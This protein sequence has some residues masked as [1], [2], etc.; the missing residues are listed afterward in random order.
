M[1]IPERIAVY[2]NSRSRRLS[3]WERITLAS[4]A[5]P[6]IPSKMPRLVTLSLDLKIEVM[7]QD[8]KKGRITKLSV[9]VIKT[10]SINPPVACQKTGSDGNYPGAYHCNDGHYQGVSNGP[11]CLPEDILAHG[12][13]PQPV[14]AGGRKVP[15]NNTPKPGI[16]GA[17]TSEGAARKQD[18]H[19]YE[20][21][22][23][24][25]ILPQ[26]DVSTLNILFSPSLTD[27]IHSGSGITKKG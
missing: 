8:G 23:E 5:Q 13:G 19:H 12:I 6:K 15:G 18:H 25:F 27:T 22:K 20:A 24:A 21:E 14:L 7:N 2:V 26:R 17:K 10:Q 4:H 9:T 3:T 1:D 16:V 11:K